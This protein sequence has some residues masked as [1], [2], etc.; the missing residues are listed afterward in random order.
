MEKEKRASRK[1]RVKHFTILMTTV[2]PHHYSDF[3]SFIG[4]GPS[5]KAR[6][7]FLGKNDAVFSN[8][9]VHHRHFSVLSQPWKRIIELEFENFQSSFMRMIQG[10]TQQH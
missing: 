9:H 7:R 6:S 5:T 4:R 3:T 10:F 2:A 8:G 1:E